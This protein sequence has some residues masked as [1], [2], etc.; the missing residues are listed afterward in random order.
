G[1]YPPEQSFSKDYGHDIITMRNDLAHCIS[2][3]DA[4]KEVLKV[5]RKG[6]GDIIFDSELFKIIRQNIRKYKTIMITLLE[7]I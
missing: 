1:I 6:A 2:Y 7:H 3:N 4:G 5:K